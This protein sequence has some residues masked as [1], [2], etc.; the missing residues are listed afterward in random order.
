ME[1]RMEIN[2]KIPEKTTAQRAAPISKLEQPNIQNGIL[3]V[4]IAKFPSQHATYRTT[5]I[6]LWNASEAHISR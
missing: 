5:Q 4:T 2:V 3:T 1:K 6:A